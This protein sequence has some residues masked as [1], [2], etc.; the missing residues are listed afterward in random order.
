MNNHPTPLSAEQLAAVKRFYAPGLDCLW[1]DPKD[2]PRELIPL[3]LAADYDALLAE[4]QRLTA[5]NQQLRDTVDAINENAANV[6]DDL[7][8][9]INQLRADAERLREILRDAN[10]SVRFH[11]G[12]GQKF[13][14][15]IGD[16]P[17]RIDAALN[18]GG[19]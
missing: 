15:S 2:A 13:R 7:H 12:S 14:E 11:R 18:Q 17:E 10:N 1:R 8:K 5:E 6:I 3:V 19:K 9:E 4:V 16:L